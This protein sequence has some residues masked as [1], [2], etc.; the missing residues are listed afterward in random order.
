MSP[1]SAVFVRCRVGPFI[2]S[3][4]IAFFY[5]LVPPGYT[6]IV[7][8]EREQRQRQLQEQQQHHSMQQATTA[9]HPALQQV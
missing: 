9:T 2:A 6:V 7:K 8:A 1:C 3:C 4:I 5:R